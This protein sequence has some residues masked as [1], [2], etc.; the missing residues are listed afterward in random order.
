MLLLSC[1]LPVSVA[2]LHFHSQLL[3]SS[4]TSLD[5]KVSDAH[6]THQMHTSEPEIVGHSGTFG[7]LFCEF[8]ESGHTTLSTYY[9]LRKY[10]ILDAALVS[11]PRVQMLLNPWQD[12][13]HEN[14]VLDLDS[15]PN[16][17]SSLTKL[18]IIWTLDCPFLAGS[19]VPKFM[20]I[21]WTKLHDQTNSG[22]HQNFN[23]NSSNYRSQKTHSP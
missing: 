21:K 12:Q 5:S 3:S 9:I 2:L 10:S 19:L 4:V 15:R 1:N 13:Y 17:P 18:W 16:L 20:L 11:R 7:I 8:C 14:M 23:S 22:L 6:F